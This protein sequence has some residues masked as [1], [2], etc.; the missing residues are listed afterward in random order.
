MIHS[1]SEFITQNVFQMINNIH[2]MNIYLASIVV[3]AVETMN[4]TQ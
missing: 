4:K 1:V 3:K 2:S